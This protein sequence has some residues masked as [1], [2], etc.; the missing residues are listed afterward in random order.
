MNA[1]VV[2]YTYLS[3]VV[4]TTLQREEETSVTLI[5]CT[6]NNCL[7]ERA[8]TSLESRLEERLALVDRSDNYY[9]PS[10]QPHIID[11]VAY[12]QLR[13]YNTHTSTPMDTVTQ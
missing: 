3:Y 7:V 4:Q 6:T 10:Q 8:S 11:T 13:T 2:V 9:L 12:I 1:A 5:I